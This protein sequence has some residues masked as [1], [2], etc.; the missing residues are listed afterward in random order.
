MKKNTTILTGTLALATLLISTA[1]T[2]ENNDPVIEGICNSTEKSSG[3]MTGKTQSPQDLLTS[4]NSC[5]GCH[6]GGATTPVITITASPA[7]G[8]GNT[9]VPGT[10][11]TISY[12]VTGYAKYGFDLEIGNSN[13]TTAT[14]IGTLLAGT[15]TQIFSS[16]VTHTTPI[17]SSTAATFHW[18][19]P[20]SGTAYLYS[21]GLGVN[22][23]GNTSGDKQAFS[24]MVLTPVAA[25][26]ENISI[27]NEMKLFP[28]PSKGISTLSYSLNSDSH[29]SIN[30]IDL[31][32]KIVSEQVNEKQSEGSYSK[33]LDLNQLNSG[34]YFV[35]IKSDNKVNTKKLIIE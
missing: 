32:G 27:N 7:F 14:A 9:Y 6:S 10:D 31:N 1:F 18:V 21:T 16:E 8:A 23:T 29:V 12:Q 24:N 13:T 15:N 11:Y 2:L 35:K 33:K 28:N 26:I 17:S 30:I 22:G 34:T 4:P 20:T 19:A 5:E 25:G 3:G